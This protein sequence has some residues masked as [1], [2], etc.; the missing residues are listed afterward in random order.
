VFEDLPVLGN[1]QQGAVDLFCKVRK[2]I[3]L[4]GNDQILFLL[5]Q[6]K[7]FSQITFL[8]GYGWVLE[9]HI[10]KLAVDDCRGKNTAYSRGNARPG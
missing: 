1:V 10:A 2:G 8:E 3:G 7:C 6:R 9:Q 4:D 5:A